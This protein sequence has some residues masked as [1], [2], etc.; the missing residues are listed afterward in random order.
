MEIIIDELPDGVLDLLDGVLD[1]CTLRSP[2]E[3]MPPRPVVMGVKRALGLP[4]V[5]VVRYP[6]LGKNKRPVW[7]YTMERIA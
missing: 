4:V 5:G 2:P 1:K 7:A 3:I 6:T